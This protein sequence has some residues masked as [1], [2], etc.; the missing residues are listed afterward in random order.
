M[1][2]RSH[3]SACSQ[4]I[5]KGI[6]APLSGTWTDYNS[7]YLPP[8]LSG[9][10][11]DDQKVYLNFDLVDFTDIQ[12]GRLYLSQVDV[13]SFND[14]PQSVATPVI[15]LDSQADFSAWQ[16]IDAPSVYGTVAS[17]S[18]ATGLYLESGQEPSPPSGMDG[19]PDYG[20]W[21]LLEANSTISFEA[22][23]LYRARFTLNVPNSAT[24]Q[25]ASRIRVRLHNAAY[26]WNNIYE[27]F[28]GNTG[29]YKDHMPAP[30]GTEYSIPMYFL[31]LFG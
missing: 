31:I 5:D 21:E 25:T 26:D 17:G 15:S 29:G 20:A 27:I 2:F 1:L 13:Q 11:A 30:G 18:D 14:I 19:L 7:Y 12:S 10:P 16:N 4:T 24:Q 9:L 23:R 3:L 28:P 22:D 6:N 8:D